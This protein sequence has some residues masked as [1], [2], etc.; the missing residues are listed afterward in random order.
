M[1]DINIL[2]DSKHVLGEGPIWDT[3]E[4]RLYF[5]DTVGGE[6]SRCAPDGSGVESWKMPG[7]I[8]SFALRKDGGALVALD[9]GLQFFDFVSGEFT[10]IANPEEGK[11]G[12]RFND[13][14]VDRMGRFVVASLDLQASS[15]SKPWRGRLFRLDTDLS[16][17][18]LDAGFW[19]SNGPCWSPD[20][21]RFYITDSR[22]D[23]I[24]AYDWDAGAGTVSN[25]SLF[26]KVDPGALPDGATVDAEGFLWSASCGAETGTGE[27]RRYAPDGT[28]DR[29]VPMP[30]PKITSLTFGGPDLDIAYVTTMSIPTN[31]A[32]TPLDGKL[33]VIK[34]LGVQ[35]IPEPR[36]GG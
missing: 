31:I 11:E 19:I 28:L 36:F 15:N 13:G 4:Q 33:L 29:V 3:D 32:E 6:L 16:L 23:G 22:S 34:G 1:I 8:G 20:D 18:E 9:S 35:G 24:Y 26:V 21:K 5:V 30:T 17:H 25:K 14:K 7:E 10:C 12:V 2:V 27:L